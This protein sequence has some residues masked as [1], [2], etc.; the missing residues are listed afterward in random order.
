M[1]FG[2]PRVGVGREFPG[3]EELA[4]VLA[5]DRKAQPRDAGGH[6]LPDGAGRTKAVLGQRV[7]GAAVAAGFKRVDYHFNAELPSRRRSP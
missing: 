6:V 7:C 3:R 4:A 1:R 2:V 5:Y